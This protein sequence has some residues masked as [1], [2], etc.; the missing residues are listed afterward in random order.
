[1]ILGLGDGGLGL[2]HPENEGHNVICEVLSITEGFEF[3]VH[4]I[5]VVV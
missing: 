5:S 4:D 2:L 3:L 1:M